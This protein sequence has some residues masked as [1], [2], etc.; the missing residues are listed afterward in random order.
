MYRT[1]SE[2]VRVNI[3]MDDHSAMIE[4]KV[5]SEFRAME[6]RLSNELQAMGATVCSMLLQSLSAST[7][8]TTVALLRYDWTTV[9]SG[10]H[11]DQS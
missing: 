3:L 9:H 8:S 2:L 6:H 1:A 11:S 4:A 10:G 5:A 7:G